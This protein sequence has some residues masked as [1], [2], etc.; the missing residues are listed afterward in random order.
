[1]SKEKLEVGNEI[2][3]AGA[4]YEVAEIKDFPHGK[5]IGIYDESPSKH[6]D[7]LNPSSVSEVYPCN[8]CQGGGCPSC[9]GYGRIV[10]SQGCR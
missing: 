1:M 4:F 7:Y 2:F 8:G 5:M 3:Y 6:I 9:A 10:G